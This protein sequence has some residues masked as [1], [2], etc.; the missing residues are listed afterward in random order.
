VNYV[1]RYVQKVNKNRSQLPIRARTKLG[2]GLLAFSY[3]Q[4]LI[5]FFLLAFSYWLLFFCNGLLAFFLLAYW[6]FLI[7]CCFSATRRLIGLLA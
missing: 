2:Q 4:I 7:G 3:G 1:R 6:L 5:G